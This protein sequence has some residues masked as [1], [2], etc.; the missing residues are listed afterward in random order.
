ME[1]HQV[2]LEPE[3]GLAGAGTADYQHVFVAGGLGV[4]WAAAH[5]KAFRLGEDDVVLEFGRDIGGNIFMAS[6][7]RGP[8]LHARAVLLGVF[9]LHVDSQ[10]ERRAAAQP[11]QQ[12]QRVKAGPET[13]ER[14]RKNGDQ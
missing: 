6:P 1:L 10:P 11:D 5:G 7:T 14:R 13:S 4:L 12:V 2:G 3:P 9:A 8:V